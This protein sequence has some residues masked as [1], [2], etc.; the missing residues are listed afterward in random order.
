MKTSCSCSREEFPIKCQKIG[1]DVQHVSGKSTT[2][3]QFF[4]CSDCCSIWQIIVD[5]GLG[6]G[7]TY[8]KK[9]TDF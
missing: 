9:I 6:G 8:R 2:T 4:Q 7:G 5:G 3:Y 1:R